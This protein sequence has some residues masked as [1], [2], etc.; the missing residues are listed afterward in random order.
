M[1]QLLV[2]YIQRAAAAHEIKIKRASGS[3]HAVVQACTYSRTPIPGQKNKGT[4]FRSA[5]E[6]S[7]VVQPTVGCTTFES[8][9]PDRKMVPS[10]GA[11]VK[12]MVFYHYRHMKT[13][14]PDHYFSRSC[15]DKEHSGLH[16]FSVTSP[17]SGLTKNT[18]LPTLLLP[19]VH[20]EGQSL[21]H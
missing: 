15:R 8:S 10:L 4:I 7:K 18:L 9:F 19:R 6:D 21:V 20:W 17:T 16:V 11:L 1:Q 14:S 13:A 3:T 5:I 2:E 12:N